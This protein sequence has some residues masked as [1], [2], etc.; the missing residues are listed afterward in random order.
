[1][2]IGSNER[3]RR[4]DVP[5]DKF[6]QNRPP[7]MAEFGQN[8]QQPVVFSAQPTNLAEGYCYPPVRLSVLLLT[9]EMRL[10]VR[11]ILV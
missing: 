7:E 9:F 5:F 3:S 1:M 11:G 8:I 6:G 2:I 4:I 10:F